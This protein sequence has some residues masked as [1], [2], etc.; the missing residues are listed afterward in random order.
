MKQPN[1]KIEALI[2]ELCPDGVEFMELGEIGT[3]LSKGTLKTGELSNQGK[4]PVINSGRS[5]YG[6]YD[7]YNNEGNAITFAARGEYAGFVNYMY[8]KFWAGGLSYPYRSKDEYK[9]IT[10]FIFYY[11]KNK[12]EFIRET[13]V[14][15]GSIP[16]INKSDVERIKIPVP[17]LPVQE[18]IVRILDHFTELEQEQTQ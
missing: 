16:A 17:P 5:W 8:E 10:K 7:N 15:H 12:Q 14:A 13:L 4:Y 1:S 9:F 3:S 18:E 6:R 11:L 2:Q